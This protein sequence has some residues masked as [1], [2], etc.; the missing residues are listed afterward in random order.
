MSNKNGSNWIRRAKRLRI[1]ARDR[2]RCVWCS[3]HVTPG[4]DGNAT[5]D[6]FLARHAG[7]SNHET[8]L[9]TCCL[10]CN[11]ARQELSA[12]E[13]AYTRPGKRAPHA[14]LERC[15]AALDRP[16]PAPRPVAKTLTYKL[17]ERAA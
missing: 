2:Y 15:F 6:H 16:L 12:L 13:F 11:S 14:V 3:A 8:N 7:G 4:W 9:L 10:T 1:Y 5:L 17:G